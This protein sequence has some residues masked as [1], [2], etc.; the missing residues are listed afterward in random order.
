MHTKSTPYISRVIE[1][2]LITSATSSKKTYHIALDIQNGEL[3]FDAGDSVGVLPMND[4]NLVE[5]ILRYF[6]VSGDERLEFRDFLLYKANIHKVNDAFLNLVSLKKTDLT[7]CEILHQH[8]PKICLSEMCRTLMPLMPRFYS[9]ASSSYVFPNEIHLLVAHVSYVLHGQ[10]HFGVGSHF[11]CDLATPSTPIPIY[12]QKAHNFRLPKDPNVPIIMIGP[13][14]GI[15][16]F[17]AFMQERIATQADGKNWLFFG[18][19]NRQSDFYYEPYWLELEKGGH[20]RVDLAFSRDQGEKV[21]VQHKMWERR[22]KIWEWIE[23]GCHVYV[24]GDAK[25]MAK[26]VDRMLQKV[27]MEEAGKNDEDARR[28]VRE[29]KKEG[30]YLLDVY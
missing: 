29:L 17:R 2:S 7:L 22:G 13:G 24:C 12:V 23:G 3:P 26:D 19:R 14:T 1:R 8:Q 10:M 9:I 25:E 6:K 27:V 30:R 15:A 28:F 20:L 18:E 5:E 11:L 16:P 21:Y 4:P